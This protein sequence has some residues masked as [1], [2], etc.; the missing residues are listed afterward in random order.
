[1]AAVLVAVLSVVMLE[2]QRDGVSSERM[3]LASTPVTVWRSNE[4]EGGPLVVVAHGYAGS[5]QMMQPISIALARAGFVVAAFDFLGH[6]RNTDPM[7]GDVASLEGATARLVEQT[8]AVAQA[9]RDLP[10]VTGPISLVGHSMA[11]D[12]V[13]RTAE[14][15]D[16]VAAVVAISMYSDAVTPNSPERLLIVSG[17]REGRLRDVAL[18]RLHQIDTEAI[19]GETVTNGAVVRRAVAAPSVGHVG[20]LYSQFT[21]TEVR[22]WIAATAGSKSVGPLPHIAPWLLTLL[23]SLVVLMWPLSNALGPPLVRPAQLG[24]RII[25]ILVAPIAP[26]LLAAIVILPGMGGL[27]AFGAL[28]V[29]TGTWGAVQLALLWRVGVRPARIRPRAIAL[30]LVWGLGIF[31]LALNHYGAAFVPTGRRLGIMLMLMLGTVP[32]C[33]ADA[34]VVARSGWI[35]SLGQR[36]LPLLTLLCAMLVSTELGIAFTVLPVMVL[37]WM[38]YGLAGGWVQKRSDPTS[39]GFVLGVILAWSVAASTPLVA[40]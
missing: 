15:I 4:I 28:T 8:I 1:M 23:I 34:L 25:L 27:F 11:T 17:A 16:D 33:V 29:F 6:G 24:R 18:G 26:A 30:M 37:F 39:V 40:S 22:D 13:I 20:V 5:R 14:R 21:L 38:V 19:E 3:T 35:A 9:A 36:I 10:G 32:F 12:V 7:T 2:R 31:A